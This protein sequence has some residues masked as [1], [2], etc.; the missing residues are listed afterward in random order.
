MTAGNNSHRA[1]GKRAG[2]AIAAAVG[3]L[4]T[5]LTVIGA[6]EAEA[7]SSNGWSGFV[8]A[9]TIY[10]YD[11]DGQ[12]ID[13]VERVNL[14][15][16][17]VD[18]PILFDGDYSGVS[19]I[20]APCPTHVTETTHPFEPIEYPFDVTSTFP[21]VGTAG[22]YDVD[23]GLMQ[24]LSTHSL[25]AGCFPPSVSETSFPLGSQGLNL[26]QQSAAEGWT[27]LSGDVEL[28]ATLSPGEIT[29]VTFY[30]WS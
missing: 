16:G 29:Y 26:P 18:E 1:V 25:T 19:H 6:A 13:F 3:L 17:G 12:T 9:H 27:F 7:A 14:T 21:S 2:V 22:M 10:A 23:I 15:F 28:N 8:R 11:Q 24:V 30:E 20:D 4:A 5:L